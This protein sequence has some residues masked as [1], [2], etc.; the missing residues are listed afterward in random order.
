[1]PSAGPK[2]APTR[3]GAIYCRV[4]TDPQEEDGTSLE[5]Q[6]AACQALAA[7]EGI[8]VPAEHVF[9]E[10][11][12]G[13][14]LWERP[15]L[16]PLRELIQRRQLDVVLCYALDRLSRNQV[17]TAILLDELDRHRTRLQMVTEQFENTAIGKFLLSARA[18][19]AELEREK[20]T[21]RTLRG[22]R[23]RL[24]SGR[25]L[26]S[27][28]PLFGYRWRESAAGLGPHDRDWRV[29]YDEDPETAPWVRR[30]FAWAVDGWSLRQIAR[31][32]N[33]LGVRTPRKQKDWVHTTVRGILVNPSYM[34]HRAGFRWQAT[35]NEQ[36]GTTMIERPAAEQIPL[37]AGVVPPLVTADVFETVQ[38][39]MRLN[40]ERVGRNLRYPE[41]ALLRGGYARCGVCGGTLSPRRSGPGGKWWQYRCI[42]GMS[43]DP[44][45]TGTHIAVHRL[46]G[47]VWARVSR[48]LLTP[49][50]IGAE[51][52]RQQAEDPTAADLARLDG[53][54]AQVARQQQN[55]VDQLANVSGRV[56]TLV[57]EKLAELERLQTRLDDE[58]GACV[59]RQA[60]WRE[61]Q[62]RL[63]ELQ[64]WC[65][66]VA[67]NLDTLDFAG[68]RDALEALGVRV[69]VWRKE[70]VPRWDVTASVPLSREAT[71]D[72]AR[73]QSVQS[74]LVTLRW[75]APGRLPEELS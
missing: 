47:P 51:I 16:T 41:I 46:D 27:G 3:R 64:T 44:T 18:F 60:A 45:C 50:V 6:L 15:K 65:R 4:S 33:R 69:T 40:K 55:L 57:T 12:S 20:I 63:G 11:F 30:M 39:R 70:H 2:L 24:Q 38:Q 52:T 32:L 49:E 28:R 7:A 73:P 17:H 72:G 62:R 66:T 35:R 34:G 37:P 75:T 67:A 9:L 8:V 5:T 29:A 1:M 26:R 42:R 59:Q 53:E 56:A 22:K 58:R 61:A 71:V 23:G 13:F 31:E 14:R 36:G 25:L 19:S 54:R 74:S 48:V 10:T 68:R 21:E 43:L